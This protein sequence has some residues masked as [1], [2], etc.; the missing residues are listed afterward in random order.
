MEP[1]LQLPRNSKFRGNL[2]FFLVYK[3]HAADDKST[4][5][6]PV[7]KS[8]IKPVESDKDVTRFVFS[9]FKSNVPDLC[10]DDLD[11]DV[12]IEFFTS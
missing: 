3:M 9:K 6:K 12:K 4:L 8:E 5:W 2:V 7:Y 1:V 11:E 10:G